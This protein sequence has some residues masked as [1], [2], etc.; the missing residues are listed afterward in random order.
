MDYI[1]FDGIKYHK[2]AHVDCYDLLFSMVDSYARGKLLDVAAGAGYTSARLR[3]IGF[4]VTAT[5]IH[6]DQ[7]QPKEIPLVTADLN[8]GFPF[9]DAT[10]DTVVALEI[11]EHVE[12]PNQ[13]LREIARVLRPGGHVVLS[14]PNIL[15]MRSRFRFLFKGEFHLFYDMERRLKDPFFAAATGHISPMPYWLLRHFCH[16]AGLSLRRPWYTREFAGMRGPL[17][18][19]NLLLEL[20]RAT[21]AS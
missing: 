12:N 7:F 8:R 18:S 4:D 11:I 21:P 5:D 2:R 14:T 6:A 10:F 20:Q 3:K 1:E 15:C 16:D 19:T 9:P 13:F 17:V